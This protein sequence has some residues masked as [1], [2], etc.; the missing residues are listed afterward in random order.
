MTEDERYK[1]VTCEECGA[2]F[3]G[4]FTRRFC[5]NCRRLRNIATVKRCRARIPKEKIREQRRR[6]NLTHREQVAA[7]KRAWL[8]AHP[9][10]KREYYL[11][12]KAEKNVD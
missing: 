7:A 11:R 2:K 10:Y 6:Y 12:K 5:D 4:Y 1:I 3:T 8:A 9:N